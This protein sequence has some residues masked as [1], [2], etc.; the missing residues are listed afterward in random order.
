[1][2]FK[3]KKGSLT[4]CV[5]PGCNNTY[6]NTV[7]RWPKVRFYSFPSVKERRNVWIKF[8][9]RS[10]IDGSDWIPSKHSKICSEH[11]LSGFKTNEENHPS[12][13]PSLH[14]MK[15][16]PSMRDPKRALER[17]AR[18]TK[19]KILKVESTSTSKITNLQN[20]FDSVDKSCQTEMVSYD[21]HLTE[22][23]IEHD[24]QNVKTQVNHIANQKIDVSVGPSAQI[25]CF[26]GYETIIQKLNNI[27]S[28]DFNR[29]YLEKLTSIRWPVFEMFIMI[30]NE[31]QY[32]PRKV[33]IE[34]MLL[35]F[36]L[37]L[38][39]DLSFTLLSIF[40]DVPVSTLSNN[41]YLILDILY[42]RTKKGFVEW[43]SKD[44]IQATMPECFKKHFPNTR[45]IIDCTEIKTERPSSLQKS[46]ML[47]SMYKSGTMLKFLVCIAPNGL[48]TFISKA[49]G[50]RS[51]DTFITNNSGFLKL[52]SPK[53]EVLADKGFP[54]IK[55]DGVITVIPPRANKNTGFSSE[56]K[57][58]SHKIGNVRIYV[59]RVIMRLKTFK[60]LTNRFPISLLPHSDKII[61]I[62]AVIVNLQKTI[63]SSTSS[64]ALEL[65]PE[66]DD[67]SV[68]DINN[69]EENDCNVCIDNLEHTFADFF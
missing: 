20:V 27:N 33:R 69:L 19:R 43:P 47:Y 28:N 68:P 65:D 48:I 15:T 16:F 49:F 52:L 7:G 50:G 31:E 44:V 67:C 41:F 55:S 21:N 39:H 38:R 10:N 62:C 25:S 46:S 2:S 24:M 45:C 26:Y 8:V 56:E 64:A 3:Q 66:I 40:F 36:L 53:D 1:M 57:A 34:N 61:H 23:Y 29:N 60:I 63:I 59:E 4:N 5:V 13:N 51:S 22:F 11:F 54:K 14:P 30:L 17:L 6:Q 37:K 9:S 42:E 32:K 35:I 12:F 58:L 18:H